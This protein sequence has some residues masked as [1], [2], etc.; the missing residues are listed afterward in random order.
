[1]IGEA[2]Y[3][4]CPECSHIDCA[5]SRRLLNEQCRLCGCGFQQGDRFFRDRLNSDRIVHAACEYSQSKVPA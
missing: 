4:V 1:M 5:E 2:E 3:Q